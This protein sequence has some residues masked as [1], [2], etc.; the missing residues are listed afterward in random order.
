MDFQN[1]EIKSDDYHDYVIK[2]GRLIG[3]FEQMYKNSRDI[4]WHQDRQEDWLD[5]QLSIM[6][7][8]Q[9]GQFDSMVDF[10]CGL[11][12]F[13]DT[14]YRL[15]GSNSCNLNGYDIAQTACSKGKEIFPHINFH[16]LNL[17]EDVGKDFTYNISSKEANSKCLFMLRGVL[18]YVFPKI[19][20]VVR[21]ISRMAEIGDYFL[22]SQNFPPLHSSFV[23][24]EVIPGPQAI[25]DLFGGVFKPLKAIW[26]ED[27]MS[28]GNED[29]FV[30]VMERI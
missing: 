8:K 24:K 7:L 28:D 3:E 27:K 2:D 15:C 22:V 10:G 1:R 16:E 25:L 4:P 26:Y 23:G 9:Y 17:M 6:L 20:N 13:L 30:S 21:N 18:W 5:I 12:Y 11:G 19:Q 14:I 29:W